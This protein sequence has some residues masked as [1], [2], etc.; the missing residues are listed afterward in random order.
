MTLILFDIDGTLT[1]TTVCDAECYA[2]AFEHIFGFALPSTDWHDYTHVTDTGIIAEALQRAGRSPLSD[3]QLLAFESHFLREVQRAHR[4]TPEAFAEIPGAKA[5]LER[6]SGHSDVTVALSTGGMKSTAT[7][8]L[9]SIGVDASAFPGGFANDARSRSDIAR[10]AMDRANVSTTDIVY[11]GDGLWDA[12]TSS[13]L[14][15]RFIGIT[16]ESSRDRLR[17]AGATVFL[18]DYLDQDAFLAAV[19][20]ATVP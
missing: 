11:V 6:L 4:D 1:A 20:L 7:F 3:E 17:S 5:I 9:N 18:D 19:R 10:I 15:I 12:L 13:A 16:R 8:K 2:T 14:G